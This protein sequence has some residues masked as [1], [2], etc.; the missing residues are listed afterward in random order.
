MGQES[1]LFGVK[2][3]WR[4]YKPYG[5][6]WD[7]DHCSFCSEKLMDVDEPDVLRYGYSTEDQYHWICENCF[8]DFKERFCWDVVISKDDVI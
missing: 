5:E 7:H 8:E 1:Y 4:K 2:L 3:Y 6:T